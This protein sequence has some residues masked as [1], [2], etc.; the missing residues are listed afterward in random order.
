MVNYIWM[1]ESI[2]TASER[3]AEELAST[4]FASICGYYWWCVTSV[5]ITSKVQ[6]HFVLFLSSYCIGSPWWN[7]LRYVQR[8]L[9]F[10]SSFFYSTSLSFSLHL[11]SVY[12]RVE[13]CPIVVRTRLNINEKVK[14]TTR[15]MSARKNLILNFDRSPSLMRSIFPACAHFSRAV[16]GKWV[17]WMC[18]FLRSMLKLARLC[19]FSFHIFMA[20]HE[21]CGLGTPQLNVAVLSLNVV[22]LSK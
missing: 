11:A 2:W 14:T 1:Y 15:K 13:C 5:D 17:L 10:F 7:A 12:T 22:V 8:L 19:H 18:W 9:L 21:Y 16:N 4:S 20:C 6:C 3:R